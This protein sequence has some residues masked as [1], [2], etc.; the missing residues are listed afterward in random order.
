MANP[1]KDGTKQAARKSVFSAAQWAR[2]AEAAGQHE[3]AVAW[4][5]AD[6]EGWDEEHYDPVAA[7]EYQKR[8]ADKRAGR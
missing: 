1:L 6:R 8:V 3:K 2:I 4:W 7:A 5:K